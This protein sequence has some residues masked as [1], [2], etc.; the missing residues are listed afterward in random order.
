MAG[1]RLATNQSSSACEVHTLQGI[2]ST[3]SVCTYVQFMPRWYRTRCVFAHYRKTNNLPYLWRLGPRGGHSTATTSIHSL[4][5]SPRFNP[6][7]APQSKA[8]NN[9]QIL[10][11]SEGAS[12]CATGLLKLHNNKTISYAT[13]HGTSPNSLLE[14]DFWHNYPR[15]GSI[16]WAKSNLTAKSLSLKLN[17]APEPEACSVQAPAPSVQDKKI[18][19][20][21]SSQGE[22][23]DTFLGAKIVSKKAVDKTTQQ[24]DGNGRIADGTQV[25]EHEISDSG[26]KDCGNLIQE[27]SREDI[28]ARGDQSISVMA[29]LKPQ[30]VLDTP[31]SVAL[32]STSEPKFNK[33]NEF[34]IHKHV[35]GKFARPRQ[36]RM[37]K[38]DQQGLS[39]QYCI[40][41]V[42]ILKPLELLQSLLQRN[43][44]STQHGAAENQ[45]QKHKFDFGSFRKIT[46]P[47]S[48]E[49]PLILPE[50]DALSSRSDIRRSKVRIRRVHLVKVRK[51]ESGHIARVIGHNLDSG[52]LPAVES[53]TVNLLSMS[54]TPRILAD[55]GRK[56]RKVKNLSGSERSPTHKKRSFR[57]VP[58]VYRRRLSNPK[59]RLPAAIHGAKSAIASGRGVR[60]WQNKSSA[61]ERYPY[62]YSTP[63]NK[64]GLGSKRQRLGMSASGYDR[65]IETQNDPV[66][67][68]EL[69]EGLED[70]LNLY[71]ADQSLEKPRS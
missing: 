24:H 35:S 30:P 25:I 34:T 62:C 21:V 6:T 23:P 63:S 27:R 26:E 19:A 43:S 11:A 49:N 54:D 2:T 12:A 50:R 37:P 57:K 9:E 61:R 31:K 42:P 71:E 53:P 13:R 7:S 64:I 29:A 20:T 32:S 65:P 14:S 66:P 3:G 33:I 52:P 10:H 46:V 68:E 4:A 70:V 17:A 18:T 56:R 28:N 55:T 44:T 1:A 22:V 58:S 48:L 41:K 51:L 36:K 60:A 16:D 5:Y 8:D 15:A 45:M 38:E 69:H 39:L 67:V 47:P 59:S 40:G